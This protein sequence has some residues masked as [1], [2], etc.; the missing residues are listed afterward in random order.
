MSVWPGLPILA[1]ALA[2][3]A[4]ADFRFFDPEDPAQVP[5][6][7]SA[8][9]FYD[10]IAA[11]R[12]T[13]RAVAFQV[14]TPLWSD[15]ASK[16]RWV[17]LKPGTRIRFSEVSDYYGYPDGAVFVKEFSL[18]TVAGEAS[19][20]IPWET[21]LLVNKRDAEG[22]DTWI[23]FS[24]RWNRQGTDAVL[25]SPDS[26]YKDVVRTWPQGRSKPARMKKWNFPSQQ[27][28]SQ[29][30]L[31]GFGETQAR[32]V[33]GFFT[34]QLNLE[35]PGTGGNQLK[36]FFD[37]GL[38]EPM[39]A[40]PDFSKSPRWASLQD[41]D[42][43]LELK[44]RSYLAANCSGCHGDRGMENGATHG[45]CRVNFDFFDMKKPEELGERRVGPL[46]YQES[47][48]G[49]PATFDSNHIVTP[50]RP[51]FSTIIYRQVQANDMVPSGDRAQWDIEGSF[52]MG[53]RNEMPPLGR[54]ESDTAAVKLL[55]A[56]INSLP[57][58][59][60]LFPEGGR[61]TVSRSMPWVS[62][63]EIRFPADDPDAGRAE[64]RDTRGV[65]V[66]LVASGPGLYRV[67]ERTAPGLHLLLT[68][69]GRAFRIL[70]H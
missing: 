53:S 33:L 12:I 27:Q 67:P 58:A 48:R 60:G 4:A 17:I 25:V 39:A 23:G 10:D 54:L 45:M 43:S 5:P 47:F 2:L 1:V 29:C 3:P 7:L 46:E 22:R 59:T 64:L 41:P 63:R 19:S 8:T 26:G 52:Y 14:N 37:I 68:G 66:P 44:A 42:A 11:K 70:L 35:L 24:Y 61:R 20:R 62:G 65:R 31:K 57:I 55:S 36:R 38:F 21:R 56:W 13:P 9:G 49:D 51:E 28:C 18:D 30:H 6:A 15:G 69:K 40:L 34:A 50:K 16:R 32:S